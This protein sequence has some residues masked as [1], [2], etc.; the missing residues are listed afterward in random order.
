VQFNFMTPGIQLPRTTATGSGSA[1][2][3]FAAIS[4]DEFVFA[5]PD[6]QGQ[7]NLRRLPPNVPCVSV[8]RAS[9]A[10]RQSNEDANSK[11]F[12]GRSMAG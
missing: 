10:F 1:P 12:R 5:D 9:F 3:D 8:H 2:G 7:A 11:E 4:A 6:L